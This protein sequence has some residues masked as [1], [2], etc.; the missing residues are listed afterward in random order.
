MNCDT[1]GRCT[2]PGICGGGGAELGPDTCS[3]LVAVLTT[4]PVLA[5]AWVPSTP[6]DLR[7]GGACN[8]LEAAWTEAYSDDDEY[9]RCEAAHHDLSCFQVQTAE[10]S[11]YA[12]PGI[13]GQR[14][15]LPLSESRC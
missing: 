5:P 8:R 6:E 11:R 14:F 7:R 12:K 2:P 10:Y 9:E 13:D 15:L 4:P 1:H 3:A